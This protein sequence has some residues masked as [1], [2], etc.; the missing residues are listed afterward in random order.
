MTRL[1]PSFGKEDREVENTLIF[2]KQQKH[3]FNVISLGPNN[4]PLIYTAMIK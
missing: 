4:P 1:S 2:N 3:C